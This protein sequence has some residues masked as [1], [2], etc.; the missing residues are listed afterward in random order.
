[1][2]EQKNAK[3]GEQ[4][5]V[6]VHISSQDV[7]PFAL[8]STQSPFFHRFGSNT[9]AYAQEAFVCVGGWR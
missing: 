4:N 3:H 1:M 6:C 8:H 5:L 9:P 2:F 7:R